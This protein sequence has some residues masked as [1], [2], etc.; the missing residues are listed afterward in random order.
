LMPLKNGL[1]SNGEYQ[2]ATG[3]KVLT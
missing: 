1:R 3:S 2:G